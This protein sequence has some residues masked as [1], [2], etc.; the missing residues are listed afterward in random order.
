ML[1]AVHTEEEW[2][3]VVGDD[4][5]MRAA[6]GDLTTRL[7]LAGRPFEK[8]PEGSFPVYRIG[9]TDVLK[10]YPT[11]SAADGVLE[12]S[13]LE[14]VHGRLAI[15]TPEVRSHGEY[16]EGWHYVLMS[17]LPGAGLAK[18][19]DRV[20]PAERDRMADTLGEAL[21][22]LHSLDT[23]PLQDIVGPKSWGGFLAEQRSTAVDRQR[24]RKLPEEWLEQIP[25]F[26]ASVPLADEPERVLLHTEVMREHLVADPASWDLTGLFDFEPAMLG[27]RAYEFGAVAVFFAKG[28]KQLLGRVLDA[29]GRRFDPRELLALKLVHVYSHLPW[30]F[31]FLPA[32]PEP[33]LDSLAE[34]WYGSE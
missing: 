29:Y 2:D 31:R 20:P 9:D 12:A 1:P 6:V 11:V 15:P 27:D 26:L 10:L 17:Q 8:Y 7:K 3:A 16:G 5:T 18:S 30:Y 34:A 32:P 28:D 13:V 33:T 19:W 24:E 25:D 4:E 21:A 14:Q 22:A 23:T